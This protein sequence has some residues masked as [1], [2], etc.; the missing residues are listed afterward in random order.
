M[1]DKVTINGQ[2]STSINFAMQQNYVPMIR[3]LIIHNETEVCLHHLRLKIE[4]EPEFAKEYSFD[5]ETIEAHESIEISPVKIQII[6]QFLFSLTEKLVGNIQI[7]VY[8][9][10]QKIYDFHHEIELLAYDQWSGLTIMPEIITAFVTPNHPKVAEILVKASAYLKEWLG[11]PAFT[12]YQTQNPTQVKYQMAA[13]YAALQSLEIIYNNP[14]ASY[15][16]IGQ[17]VRLPYQVI[18]QKQGTCLDL[19]VLYA[20]CLE[21]AGLFS[22]LIFIKGHAFAGGWLDAQTFADCMIDDISA[23]EKR[24]VEGSEELLLVECTDFTAGAQ[25]DFERALKHGKDHLLNPSEFECIIDVCRSRGS[26]IHPIPIQLP[27]LNSEA[28]PALTFSEDRVAAPKELEVRQWQKQ[29]ETPENLTKQKLWER[30]LLDFSLRNSLLNFRVNK[31]ALQL[32]CADLGELEDRLSDG[33]DFKIMEVPKEWTISIRDVK[34]Y[35]IENDKDLIQNIAAEEFKNK[36]IRTFLLEEELALHLKGLYRS[37]KVSLEEN[38]TNTLFLALGFLRWFETDLSEKPRYA[39]IILIPV[40][41][42][43]SSKNKGYVIRSRQEEAQVNITLIEYLRQIFG[44]KVLGLDPLPQDEHGIDIPRVFHILRQAVMD[45]KRWNVE[46]MAFLGLFSFGQFVMWNDLRNRS[47]ELKTSKVVSSLMEGRLTWNP[48]NSGCTLKTLDEELRPDEL[49]VPLSADSSQL[50]AVTAAAQGQSFVLHGPPGTGKSQTITNMIANALYQGKSVLFVAE[51]MAALNVVQNRLEKIGLDPFC[52]ELHSNKTNKTAVLSQLNQALEVGRYKSPEDYKETADKLLKLRKELSGSMEALHC[53]RGFGHSLYEAI[54]RYELLKRYR[55]KILLP[56]G[57]AAKTT[58]S[59]FEEWLQHIRDFAAAAE[60][61]GAYQ[62][63]PLKEYRGTEYSIDL[64]ERFG[65]QLEDLWKQITGVRASLEQFREWTN[66][67]WDESLNTLQKLSQSA[68]AALNPAETLT[69][70]LQSR[71][72]DRQLEQLR[73]ILNEGQ[74]YQ[75]AMEELGHEFD[76][77]AFHYDFSVAKQQWKQAENSWFLPKWLG[78]QKCVKELKSF[79]KNASAITKANILDYY[80]RFLFVEEQRRKLNAA[81]AEFH[82]LTEGLYQSVNTDW[83]QLREALDKAEAAYQALAGV[84]EAVRRGLMTMITQP[85]NCGRL[86]ESRAQIEKFLADQEMLKQTYHLEVAEY[87]NSGRGISE[88]AEMMSRFVHHLP[89]LKNWVILCQQAEILKQD[90]LEVLTEAWKAGTVSADQLQDVFEANLNYALIMKTMEEDERLKHFQGRLLEERI[91]QYN[92]LIERFQTL[93][94]QELVARLSAQIPVSGTVNAASS[95]IG[96]L[97]RAIKSNGRMMSIR[98]L[99]D[100]IPTLL[101]KLCPCM[102]MSPISVAQYI[103][104][105]FPKFDLVIFDEA[106]QLPTCEAVGTIARGENVVVVGDPN[107]LP[108]TN[109]F[110]ANRVDEENMEKEDLESLLDDCLSISM[111]QKYLKWHYR[112]RHESLIAFSNAKYYDNKLYTFPSPHDRISEVKFVAVD[113]YYD[114][115]KTKQNKAEARAVVDE[116]L[117]RLKDEELRKESIGVVTFSSV[118]Q[119]L[120]DD[121]LLEEFSKQPQLEEWNRQSQEPIFIKNLE[122]VQGDERDVIL[123]SVGYGPDR[124]GKVSMNF[125]PLNRDGGWRRL[126]VAVSRA[127]KKMIVYA[128]LQPEQIDLSRTRSEGVAG[129]KAFLEYAKRGQNSLAVKAGAE[130]KTSEPLVVEIANAIAGL[131]YDVKWDIGCSEYKLDIAVV[132]PQNPDTYLLGILLDGE[133]CKA[134]ATEKDRFVLQPSVLKGLGWKIMRIWT[135][136]WLDNPDKVLKEI[137]AHLDQAELEKA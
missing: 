119:N 6:T 131:G 2:L 76:T 54:E 101:R 66:Y 7:S 79:A 17:R 115:G 25:I 87:E 20:A 77:A 98:R 114:K 107:Q 29:P 35:A 5:I 67:A 78:Q 124:E 41:L 100:E 81:P 129:L 53:Q 69:T 9:E 56:E 24:V 116:I 46:N 19:A 23:L 96:I 52:M 133:N 74:Q 92:E 27:T 61:I 123:F 59:T 32:M 120:I 10:D 11:K 121:Y 28:D 43:R 36:R 12:G 134:A 57:F 126:N 65:R 108:P 113:G 70:L 72:F 90:D 42:V 110:S 125:G 13:I 93:T 39:P 94:M 51:K 68:E 95:E 88:L 31:N 109:F 135:L 45:K 21:A 73:Q 58:K 8:E 122:N 132:N 37:A 97:K 55:G 83:T 47:E 50:L 112:S 16:I 26:G 136:D 130:Q 111:P 3:S 40:D 63:H 80:D 1:A 86:P 62:E 71:F 91:H 75:A 104:P 118:Q 117:R 128:V 105:S 38:G 137:V 48:E 103:D 34:M 106:S 44:I 14:P 85:E 18:E 4:F 22:L 30:K 84:D 127:R 15:E 99:F 60:E 49:A 33:G 64:R 82:E 102:L 89:E